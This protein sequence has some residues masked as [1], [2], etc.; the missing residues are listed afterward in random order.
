[1]RNYEFA[2]DTN[3]NDSGQIWDSQPTK[4]V[5]TNQFLDQGVKPQ[6]VFTAEHFNFLLNNITNKINSFK[7]DFKFIGKIDLTLDSKFPDLNSCFLDID[8]FEGQ[9]LNGS[10]DYTHVIKKPLYNNLKH[11]I[12][13]KLNDNN[14]KGNPLLFVCSINRDKWIYS[15]QPNTVVGYSIRDIAFNQIENSWLMLAHNTSQSAIQVRKHPAR[16]TFTSW[17]SS[18]T[19]NPTVSQN[20]CYTLESSPFLSLTPSWTANIFYSDIEDDNNINVGILSSSANSYN[21]YNYW[22]ITYG[23][24]TYFFAN[25]D[26]THNHTIVVYNGSIDYFFVNNDPNTIITNCKFDYVGKHALIETANSTFTQYYYTLLN[27]QNGIQ[28]LLKTVN[29]N[30]KFSDYVMF[31]DYILAITKGFSNAPKKLLLIDT[32]SN[33]RAEYLNTPISIG[34]NK[35]KL[36]YF[37]NQG[38]DTIKVYL[39]VS[40]TDGYVIE[41]AN[42]GQPKKTVSAWDK[43]NVYEMVYTKK[44]T[45]GNWI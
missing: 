34:L 38:D 36:S 12:G 23:E 25:F 7:F 21:E 10:S 26:T 8:Y 41:Y 45:V 40:S 9:V 15:P 5:P 19:E 18:T 3:F 33:F 14:P 29:S 35:S 2:S 11:N 43:T 30:D 31:D 1:M 17:A 6:D 44:S 20:I 32:L 28:T 37:A 22:N 24:I 13:Y 16:D 42:D 39:L 4:Q 27:L